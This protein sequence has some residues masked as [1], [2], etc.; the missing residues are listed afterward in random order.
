MSSDQLSAIYD[1][2]IVGAGSSGAVLAARLS[3]DRWRSVLLLEAGPDYRAADVPREMRIPNPGPIIL[4]APQY[5]WP[6]LKAY[7]TDYQ[8]AIVYWRGRGL[9]GSSVIN[10]QIAIRPPLEDFD[11][12]AAGGSAGW[13]AA[14]VLPA[15]IKLEDDEAF[16]DRPYHGRGGPIPIYR[17]PRAEWGAV[18]RALAEAAVGCGYGW[19]DDHNAPIGTGTSPYAINSRNH[20]RV[21]T[22]DAYLEPARDR[23]NLS[24]VG[25]A[26]VDRV[27]FDGSRAVAVRVRAAGKWRRI[28]GG[29]IIL[30][31]GAI[32]S[33]AILMRSGIGPANELR[34]LGIPVRADAPVGRNLL[35]HPQLSMQ[36]DL[37]AEARA[38]TLESRHTNCCVRYTSGLA[39]AGTNDMIFIAFN[40]LGNQPEHLRYGYIWA[41]VY[42]S[43]SRGSLTINSTDPDANP[44]IRFQMLSDPRDLIRMRDAMRRLLELTEH[45]AIRAI[46]NSVRFGRAL[47]LTDDQ[48]RDRPIAVP[49]DQWMLAHCFDVQHAAG[50]CRM[51]ASSDRNAVVDP[52]CRVIGVERL[53]V[54]DASIVP[55]IVRANTHLTAVMI[56]E[57]M[58]SKIRAGAAGSVTT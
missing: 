53:R 8:R 28:E 35:D 51:G 25:G 36:L 17:A 32:H 56:G 27:E 50:T 18:D 54:V 11:I 49:T 33:P 15:F 29:E 20:T 46:A 34:A 58:A 26:M 5:Q 1:T 45:P 14:E 37:K 12:W 10:G 24:I 57:H 13:S 6:N 44:E 41:A 43:F 2:I 16:G 7:R 22:N 4:G 48:P 3:E 19:C 47:N 52:L 38:A 23:A 40:L 39:E 21:S 42:R 9:G 31:A 30:S 55:E